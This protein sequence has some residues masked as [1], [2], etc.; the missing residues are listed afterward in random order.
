MTEVLQQSVPETPTLEPNDV[1]LMGCG[2][3]KTIPSGICDLE[4]VIYGCTVGE[5]TLVVHGQT[6]KPHDHQQPPELFSPVPGAEG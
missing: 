3:L 4:V 6:K 2:G 1:V 5:P